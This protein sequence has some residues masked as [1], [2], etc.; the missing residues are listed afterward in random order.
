MNI[1]NPNITDLTLKDIA[2]VLA[3]A[4]FK[5]FSQAA[6]YC[7]V[8]QPAL[9][10][11][12]KQLENS[13]GVAL[14]ER[15][16]RHVLL[17]P[18]G[19]RFVKQAQAVMDAAEKLINVTLDDHSPLS[20]TLRIGVIASACPYLLPYFVGALKDAFPKLALII[21]EGLTENLVE[22]LR[23]GA[24]D[25][26]IAATT[27][28]DASL[29]NIPLF[30]EPFL[31]ASRKIQNEKGAQNQPEK[32]DIADID[33]ETILLLEDGHCLKDQTMELCAIQPT[34]TA[35]NFRATSLE[36]LLQ[37]TAGGLGVSVIPRL[38][39]PQSSQMSSVLRF[40]EFKNQKTGRRMALYYRKSYPA[41]ANIRALAEFIKTHLPATVRVI[42]R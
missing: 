18:S 29:A 20:G 9:S 26:V 8:S 10:K 42:E 35:L 25:A 33:S 41:L 39:V 15:S 30:F 12:L 17:T 16:K 32:I 24:L 22:S 40:S 6:I 19:E 3:I 38:A 5:S 4:R 1:K 2:Y 28:E 7:A 37:M 34:A 27:F 11:Q 13:L 31:L 21:N 14:F 23:Q 36:T